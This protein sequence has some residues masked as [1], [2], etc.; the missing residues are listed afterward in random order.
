MAGAV[1]ISDKVLLGMSGPTFL[2]HAEKIRANLIQLGAQEHIPG[3]FFGHDASASDFISAA[4]LDA[5][6]FALFARAVTLAFAELDSP[7]QS[8]AAMWGRLLDLVRAD[9]RF[10]PRDD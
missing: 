3:I 10:G 4:D 5:D 2:D 7:E 1:F 6:A 9:P 8:D